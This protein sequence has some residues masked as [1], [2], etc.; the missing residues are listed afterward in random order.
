MGK[1]G[2][3]PKGRVKIRWSSTFAYAIGLLTSDGCLSSNG[4]HI[5]FVSK[6]KEQLLNFM[7]ALGI[8]VAI[9]ATKSGYTGKPTARIQFGDVLFYRFLLG[10]GLTP[11]KSKTLGAIQVPKEHFFDFL[12]GLFD[13]DGS[14]YS[15]WDRRWK[16]SFMYYVCFAS[17]SP[18]F[19]DWLQE[20][21]RLRLGFKGHIAHAKNKSTHQLKYA[22][23]EGLKLLR[24]MYRTAPKGTYLSRK[25]LKIDRMLAIVGEQL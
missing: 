15:Y 24:Q 6:D 16:S 19:V 21:I 12:R 8:K 4:R 11:N 9:G 13:G 1:R 2:P 20:S 7:T 10:I 5:V 14:T 17:A 25:R 23:S 18:G 3:K 22:K